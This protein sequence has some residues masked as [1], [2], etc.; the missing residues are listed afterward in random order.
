MH[1]IHDAQLGQPGMCAFHVLQ[2]M[3]NHANR[4]AA[5]IQRAVGHRAHEPNGSATEDKPNTFA[6]QECAEC[7][8]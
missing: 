6:R 2:S 7:G 8:G 4:L 1:R 5:S 3:R